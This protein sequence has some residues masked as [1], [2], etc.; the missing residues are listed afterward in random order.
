MSEITLHPA[1][2]AQ[3]LEDVRTLCWAYRDF[4]M[5]QADI[6]QYI[7]ETFYP[8]PKYAALMT[9]LAAAHA[10]PTGII[11]IARDAAGM[12]MGCGMSH[13]LDA[14]TS[15]IKRV[16]V[17]DDARGKGIAAQI[18]R[19]LMSQAR[20]D[21]FERVVLDTSQSLKAAQA[22]YLKLGF[23]PRG[24]YQP[25]PEDVVAHLLFFEATL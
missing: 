12:P 17:R 10:R 15:E 14:R 21:G 25:I 23:E 18:C 7:V 5:G 3:D 16:Y 22:L 4:L 24:P 20:A 8:V 19:A 13:A 9:E 2:T 6:D 1:E 11:L